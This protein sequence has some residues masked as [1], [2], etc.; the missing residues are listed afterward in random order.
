MAFDIGSLP[1]VR[2]G[3]KSPTK[4]VLVS[5]NNFGQRIVYETR[6]DVVR[7]IQRFPD[8]AYI[9]LSQLGLR[10]PVGA[11]IKHGHQLVH[12]PEIM[13]P[14]ELATMATSVNPTRRRNPALTVVR[15]PTR[16]SR[17]RDGQVLTDRVLAI[18]YIHNADG[19]AYEH[20]FKRGVT[21]EFLPDGSAR[22]YRKDGRPLWK[23]C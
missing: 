13:L 8:G 15:N 19:K 6:A 21:V 1:S 16:T 12:L 5:N 20:K 11:W 10:R 18:Q 7:A 23:D 9:Y 22:L 17:S 3:V 14:L 4:Y 2:R